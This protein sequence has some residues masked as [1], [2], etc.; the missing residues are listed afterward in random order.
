M[1][2]PDLNQSL[3]N[4]R[5]FNKLGNSLLAHLALPYMVDHLNHCPINGIIQHIPDETTVNFQKV[6]R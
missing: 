3:L 6:D 2:D 5:A 4:L 1:I